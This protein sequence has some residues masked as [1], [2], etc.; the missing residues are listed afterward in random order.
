MEIKRIKQT[1]QTTIQD[2][3]QT[4]KTKKTTEIVSPSE[5]V[6]N[7]IVTN[8]IFTKNK[9]KIQKYIDEHGGIIRHSIIENNKVNELIETFEREIPEEDIYFERLIYEFTLIENKSF[10]EVF[11]QVR[12]IL[13]L[14]KEFPHIIRGSA[15][16]SLVCYLMNITNI[17]PIL[18]NIPLTRFMHERREDIPDVDIDFPYH[19]REEIFE[20]IYR[21]WEGRV[22]RISNHVR[23][24]EKSALK[25]AIRRTG[26]HK[27]IPKDFDVRQI[28]DDPSIQ[29]QVMEEAENLEGELRCYSLHCGGIIIFKDKVP[30]E[31]YLKDYQINKKSKDKPIMGAQ[32]TLN[33]DEAEDFNFI[34]I[35]ILSNRGLSQLW[36]I[37]Q[38]PIEDYPYDERVYEMFER[39]ETIGLTYAE[40]RGMCKI[41]R[42]MR[43]KNIEDIACALALIRPAA[44]RNGQKFTFLRDYY[45]LGVVQRDDFLIYDDDAIQF[46]SR[47]LGISHSEADIYRKAFAKNKFHKKKEFRELMDERQ[48]EN[49]TNE[50]RQLIFE[51]LE[52]LQEYSFCKSHAFSYAK[53]VYALAYQKYHNPRLFWESTLKHCHSSYRTWVHYREAKKVGVDIRRFGKGRAKEILKNQV[54]QQFSS[55]EE[56][57]RLGY[58]T[59]DNFL[60]NMYY[61]NLGLRAEDEEEENENDDKKKKKKRLPY[62][63]FRGLIVTYKIFE[64]D[65]YIKKKEKNVELKKNKYLT[66]VTLGYEDGKYVD[67]V[68]WGMLKLNK[69]HTISGEGF[70]EDENT[71]PWI[72]VKKIR[73]ERLE[74]EEED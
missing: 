3:F 71:V 9:E 11:L 6:T 31:Y 66:F 70:V 42:E 69:T 45:Q 17:N 21:K 65:R 47:I 68:I 63:E 1:K 20:R 16:C 5:I 55:I 51:Q 61:R 13:L 32:L 2:F 7:E 34:K 35:D 36:D 62:C 60:P 10:F 38:R 56:Y 48:R 4:F 28:I 33:K 26:Y 12:E 44:S 54:I 8:N 64:A 52:S 50:K 39:G 58:W 27:F 25:E 30:D 46:I 37:S 14:T 29:Y 24:K 22:A 74:E 40:S 49:M 23:F 19:C 43:P 67:L 53:L 18:E 73:F 72:R 59:G 15:G 41:F 57:F